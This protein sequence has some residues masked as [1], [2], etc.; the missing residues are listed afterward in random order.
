[1]KPH[2]K[3]TAMTP[4]TANR[5]IEENLP[6]IYGF[7]MS[8]LRDQRAAEELASDIVYAV[9]RS[10]HQLRDERGFYAWMWQIARNCYAAQLRAK[11]RTTA[12]LDDALPDD[13]RSPEDEA[14]L[15]DDL[16]R[17]RRELSLLAT[18]QRQATVLYYMD[19]L[20]CAEVAS[21]MQISTEMVK[22]HLFRARNLM[23]EGMKMERIYGEKSYAPKQFEID[24]W[25]T[26]AGDDREYR[27]FQERKIRGN[28]LLATYYTP[29]SLP[30]LSLELG[31]A[32]PYLEDEVRLLLARK[33]LTKRREK[34]VTNIPI[35]TAEC[36]AEIAQTTARLADE[37]A[38]H[39]IESAADVA[40]PRWQVLTL[41]AHFALRKNDHSDA[42]PLP[43]TEAYSLVNGGG[44][45]GYVWGR[46]ADES[47]PMTHD[48]EGIYNGAPSD[49]WRG[50]VIAFNFAQTLNVQHVETQMITP[51]VA[52]ACGCFA[53][54]PDEWQAILNRDGYVADGK[55][56][57]PVYTP[58]DYAALEAQ[59][60]DSIACVSS[61]CR[62]TATHAARIC[63]E[64]APSHIRAIAEQVGKMVYQF[65][66]LAQLAD[67]LT[68][69]GWLS[70][71]ED[72]QSPKPA[73]CVVLNK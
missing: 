69:R 70:P 60:A 14:I 50:S 72:A 22:S 56:N 52:A 64:H 42:Q 67:A 44:G 49:D 40:L 16:A 31:V 7:A 18:A 25:G 34:Y 39:F 12:A 19:G 32:V 20:S 62:D 46:S 63:A 6:A 29:M 10:A 41:C 59:L 21:Q 38:A 1:M 68:A 54:L 2:T 27:A 9:L 45:C 30:E 3:E 23:R 71:V 65:G 4:T 33:Y 53:Q 73:M 15:R 17:L 24:F 11:R 28:I 8:R 51:L 48:I 58:A 55:P 66:C 5:L 37:A 13:A 61:L 36:S 35:F 43:E 57:Y 26:K 47:T